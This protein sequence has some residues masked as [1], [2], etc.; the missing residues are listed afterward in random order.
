MAPHRTNL[1]TIIALLSSVTG[2]QAALTWPKIDRHPAPT[3]WPRREKRVSSLP[4]RDPNDTKPFELDVRCWNLAD[5]DLRDRLADLHQATFDSRTQWPAND[6]LPQDFNWRRHM[7]LGKNPGLGIRDLHRQG[8]TGRGVG[9]AILDR[10]PLVEHQEYR[11]RLRL[12][13]EINIRENSEANM[14][15]LAVASIAV[16]KTV[17]V[18]PEADLYY[19]AQPNMDIEKGK[20]T[21]NFEYLA[22][23]VHRILEINEQLPTGRKIRVISISVGWAPEQRGFE[24]ITEATQKAKAAGMLV[25][26]SSVEQV[27]GFR[28]HGLDRPPTSD[29]ED[30]ASYEPGH[31][32]ARRFYA[33]SANR[34]PNNRLLVPM[35]SRTTA[36]PTGDDEYVF[37][38][39]GA[40]SWAIPY[41][42]GMYAL[43]AQVEPNITPDQFW[44]TSLKTGKTIALH[45]EGRTHELG[46]VL[47]PARLI[48]ALRDESS[49][50]RTKASR[51]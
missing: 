34:Y 2:A 51:D 50:S 9:I 3:H 30:P 47:D 20:S 31:W 5:L 14:H 15:G 23:G 42:A 37:Y 1:L 16:G 21:W 28:F 41:I 6:R 8:I 38:R 27:H 4:R 43:A 26:C 46:P 7:E 44:T 39:L 29:P 18:A 40:W 12:Y 24:Q 32:W 33:K 49:G 17:G 45:R 25:I 36:S 13:E 10:P 11:E 48:E 35:D 19:I 22:R